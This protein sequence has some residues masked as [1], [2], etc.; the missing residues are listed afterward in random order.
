MSPPLR[1]RRDQEALWQGLASGE[2][3][4]VGTDHCSF[5]FQGQKTMGR[6]DFSMIPNGAPGIELRMQLLYAYGVAR[7]RM[8]INRYSL[9]T[10]TH[11]AKYFGLYPKK[12]ILQVGSDADIVVLDPQAEWTVTQADLHENCDYTPY[13]GFPMKGKIRQ[14]FLRGR[15][16]VASGKIVV[17][18]ADGR[19]L[20]RS[21]PDLD[22]R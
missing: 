19:Y 5:N 4:F 22:I 14:V 7:G 21:L 12:G 10:S 3:Q 15:Q 9:V 18:E 11:A 17:D 1:S 20:K 13:E 8:D 2:I 16:K 6:D